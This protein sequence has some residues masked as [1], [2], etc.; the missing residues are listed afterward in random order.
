MQK[1]CGVGGTRPTSYLHLVV[2][3]DKIKLADID[4]IISAEIPEPELNSALTRSLNEL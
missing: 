3:Q 2:V 1:N 4:K